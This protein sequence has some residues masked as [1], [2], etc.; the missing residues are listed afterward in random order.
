MFRVVRHVALEECH[1][2]PGSMKS[3]DQAAPESRMS[4]A[5]GGTDSQAE[6]PN[7]HGVRVTALPSI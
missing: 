2:V 3:P 7:P 4:V 1:S 5:P 6:D